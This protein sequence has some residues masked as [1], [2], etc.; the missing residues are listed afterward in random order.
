MHRKIIPALAALAA[1]AACQPAKTQEYYMSHQD[2]LAADLAECRQQ[3]LHLYN[4]NEADKAVLALK[5]KN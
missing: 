5:K 2:E 3:N 4:C 1:L